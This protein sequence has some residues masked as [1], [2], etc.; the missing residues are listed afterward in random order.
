MFS[1]KYWWMIGGMYLIWAVYMTLNGTMMTYFAEYELGN[2]DLMSM[3]NI[4]EKGQ[5]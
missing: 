2:R 4:L 3:M 5:P 1:N